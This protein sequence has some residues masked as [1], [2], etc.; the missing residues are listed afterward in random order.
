MA[1]KE[2]HIPGP[3]Q[4]LRESWAI[5]K[6]RFGLLLGVIII[7][8][9]ISIALLAGITPFGV[10]ALAFLDPIVTAVIAVIFVALLAII[11]TIV[12]AWSQAALV[13]AIHEHDNNPR[14]GEI[15][16]QAW[17]KIGQYWLVTLLV[18]ILTA[19]GFFLFIIPGFIF[20]V[21]F[22]F[23]IYV[24]VLENKKG[25]DALHMSRQYVEGRFWDVFGRLLVPGLIGLVISMAVNLVFKLSPDAQVISDSIG[26]LISFFL[27]PLFAIYYYT[28]YTHLKKSAGEIDLVAARK[29]NGIYIATGVVGTIIGIAFATLL[30]T[31]ASTVFPD[32][33]DLQS[34]PT[35]STSNVS[36]TS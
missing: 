15:F 7:P 20:S 12:Q 27:A 30:V 29:S 9:L 5:Y 2:T 19:G 35:P 24:A 34:T 14:V 3:D 10:A 18:F 33:A 22:T 17:S 13:I 6:K 21:W 31:V 32:K 28:L 25:M 1:R 8:A 23:A 36:L 16:K 26:S 11:M 4:L